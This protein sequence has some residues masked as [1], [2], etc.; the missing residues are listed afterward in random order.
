MSLRILHTADWQIGKPFAS[1]PDPAKRLRLQQER[2]DAIERLSVIVR[3]RSCDLVLVAGD[4]FDSPTPMKAQVSALFHKIGKIGVPVIAIPGNHDFGGPGGPWQQD[5]V[6]QEMADL[7]PN[8][9]IL[10]VEEPLILETAVIL[11][12]PLLH[13]QVV[14]DPTRWIRTACD[15]LPDDRPRIVLAHGSVQGFSSAGDE[16]AAASTNQLDIDGISIAAIDYIALG[17]WHGTKQVGPKAWYAGT[18]ETDRFP[19][20]E[21]NRPGHVLVANVARGAAPVIEELAT[22]VLRW[23]QLAWHFDA[24]SSPEG[25]LNLFSETLGTG[26]EGALLKLELTGHL[27]I[28][29]S[30]ELQK[31]IYTWDARLIRLKLRNH[32]LETPSDE[33]I[34]M[35]TE[36]TQDPLIARVAGRLLVEANAEGEAAAV[37]RIAMRELYQ[38][39]TA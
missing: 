22:G 23:K 18:P 24:E 16:D 6:R 32:V 27:T 14:H 12:A 39:A 25:L 34:R 7:A 19:K 11:P 35:L 38:A 21:D 3:E 30:L 13:R 26:A 5:F 1:V 15:S 37:A 28:G 33:E 29:E 17:D 31:L 10:T 36:R 9:S 8:F 2:L 20:G 4:L